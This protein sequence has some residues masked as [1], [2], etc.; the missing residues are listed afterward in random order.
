[1]GQG[2]IPADAGSR[3]RRSRKAEVARDHPRGCGKQFPDR[4][5][6]TLWQGIP[7]GRGAE[8]THG[9]LSVDREDHPRVSGE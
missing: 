9:A 7:G 1:M 2:T 5:G 4:A 8:C 6:L 3:E